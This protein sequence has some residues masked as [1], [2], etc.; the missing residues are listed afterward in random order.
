MRRWK[1]VIILASAASALAVGLGAQAHTDHT[2]LLAV[3]SN[4]LGSIT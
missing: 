2:D 4:A 1:F 3:F